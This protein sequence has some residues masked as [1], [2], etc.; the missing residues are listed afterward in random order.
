MMD[1]QVPPLGQNKR[2]GLLVRISRERACR[3][4]G[5]PKF[6]HTRPIRHG[7]SLRLSLTFFVQ[8]A[9]DLKCMGFRQYSAGRTANCSQFPPCVARRSHRHRQSLLFGPYR[10]L[11]GEGEMH[12]RLTMRDRHTTTAEHMPQSHCRHA[13]WTRAHPTRGSGARRFRRGA[14]RLILENRPHP[15]QGFK[16]CLGILRLDRPY[17]GDRLNAACLLGLEI[18]SPFL[19]QRAV[20]PAPRARPS[21]RSHAGTRRCPA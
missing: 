5:Q 8:F 6:P 21:V 14:G 1:R 15:E 4:T 17:G 16:A 3:K 19:R 18:G 20:D 7:F 12:Q 10:L 9:C 11:G 2:N 13:E